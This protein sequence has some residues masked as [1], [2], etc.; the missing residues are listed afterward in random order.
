MSTAIT[1]FLVLRREL[2]DHHCRVS[3][4]TLY[5]QSVLSFLRKPRT[6]TRRPTSS[7]RNPDVRRPLHIDRQSLAAEATAT[8]CLPSQSRTLNIESGENGTMFSRSPKVKLVESS[9]CLDETHCASPRRVT[10]DP[11]GK[12]RDRISLWYLLLVQPRIKKFSSLR[13]FSIR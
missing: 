2:I 8:Q 1:G 5:L 13:R 3:V 7:G 11:L 12:S 4:T 9:R 6:T 10:R